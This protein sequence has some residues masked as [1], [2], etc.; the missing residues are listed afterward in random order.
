MP[1]ALTHEFPA[2]MGHMRQSDIPGPF[3]S[4]HS[5]SAVAYDVLNK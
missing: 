1:D 3:T 2:S 4:R 5:G